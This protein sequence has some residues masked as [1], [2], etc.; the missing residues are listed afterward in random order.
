MGTRWEG[1]G[2]GGGQGLK[3]KLTPAASSPSPC[4]GPGPGLGAG[5]EAP[6]IDPVSHTQARTLGSLAMCW[7]K[8]LLAPEA[9]L[10][11]KPC[12]LA[13]SQLLR[14]HQCDLEQL[15]L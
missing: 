11:K 6:L 5:S 15:P 2:G 9:L 14:T 13:G 12:P 8:L 4:C 1:V 7:G 3:G 10:S